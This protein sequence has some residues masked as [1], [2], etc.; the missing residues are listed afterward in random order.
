M[1]GRQTGICGEQVGGYPMGGG[2][3][4]GAGMVWDNIRRGSRV[5]SGYEFF[6]CVRVWVAT[7]RTCRTRLT[8]LLSGVTLESPLSLEV[9]GV[10]LDGYSRG[11]LDMVFMDASGWVAHVR[12][13]DIFV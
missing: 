2:V 3:P 13:S 7:I 11:H 4:A 1:D 10:I 8:S 9:I 6:S 5:G 12:L